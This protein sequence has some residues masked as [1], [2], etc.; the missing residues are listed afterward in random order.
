MGLVV[1]IWQ[2]IL[3]KILKQRVTNKGRFVRRFFDAIAS[4]GLFVSKG[5]KKKKTLVAIIFLQDFQSYD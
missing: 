2:L 3:K 5:L 1:Y 4:R